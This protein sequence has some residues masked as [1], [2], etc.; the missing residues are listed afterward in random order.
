MT[1]SNGQAAV[2]VR[3]WGAVVPKW[4]S[5]QLVCRDR[6]SPLRILVSSTIVLRSCLVKKDTLFMVDPLSRLY[7]P[8]PAT[9][10]LNVSL[11]AYNTY[12]KQWVS[13]G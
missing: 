4:M 3:K 10:E 6:S 12:R 1:P 11:Y 5:G 2:A 7:F 8:T 9:V 13:R